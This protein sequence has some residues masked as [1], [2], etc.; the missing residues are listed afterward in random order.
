VKGIRCKVSGCKGVKVK[1][2]KCER[3]YVGQGGKIRWL[4]SFV[5]NGAPQDDK[6][7][8]RELEMEGGRALQG[9]AST[10]GEKFCR[11]TEDLIGF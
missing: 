10:V 4:R 9:N 5:A 1:G 3:C 2:C 7:L 11:V 8:L 6:L